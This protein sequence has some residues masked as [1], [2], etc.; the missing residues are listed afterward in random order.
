[1]IDTPPEECKGLSCK[2]SFKLLHFLCKRKKRKPPEIENLS[3]EESFISDQRISRYLLLI[4][5]PSPPP[6]STPT[7]KILTR[8]YQ[9]KRPRLPFSFVFLRLVINPTQACR[10]VFNWVS[11][12]IRQL[13]CFMITSLS[14]WFKVLAPFRSETKP[15]RG[16]R[17]H[18]FPRFV[19]AKCNYFE[20]WLVCR[21]VSVLFDWPK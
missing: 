10:A 7:W 11:K 21:I 18:I 13:L 20:F 1:M 5:S 9:G 8:A 3:E 17:V 16:S 19:S 14:D 6:P 2:C 15:N 12:I 4:A